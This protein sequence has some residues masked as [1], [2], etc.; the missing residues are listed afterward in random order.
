MQTAMTQHSTRMGQTRDGEGCNGTALSCST[1]PAYY[2]NENSTDI[3]QKKV[4]FS[5]LGLATT[6][7]RSM[8]WQTVLIHVE[9]RPFAIM[10]DFIPNSWKTNSFFQFISPA[11]KDWIKIDWLKLRNEI[12]KS[13]W[14]AAI[15]VIKEFY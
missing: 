10:M 3:A 5:D 6:G 8:I 12:H 14:M 15:V 13:S 1:L 11:K 9:N 2:V 4:D 7:R